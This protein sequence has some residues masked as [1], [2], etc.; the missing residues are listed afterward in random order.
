MCLMH[1]LLSSC[2]YSFLLRIILN[3]YEHMAQCNCCGTS[4]SSSTTCALKVHRNHCRK[5]A[6]MRFK[7]LAS[8]VPKPQIYVEES[9]VIFCAVIPIF[10]QLAINNI[11]DFQTIFYLAQE[12]QME[13]DIHLEV[14]LMP[15]FIEGASVYYFYILLIN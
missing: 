14:V 15:E 1:D 4:L 10:E 3:S 6:P 12:T 7:E 8:Q 2:S 9:E 5:N 11:Q 13:V